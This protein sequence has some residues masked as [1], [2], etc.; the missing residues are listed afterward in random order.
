MEENKIVRKV[1]RKPIDSE[2]KSNVNNNAQSLFKIMNVVM[3]IMVFVIFIR[4]FNVKSTVREESKSTQEKVGEM[5]I[6]M[7]GSLE[8]SRQ[9]DKNEILSAFAL[10]SRLDV[11]ALKEREDYHKEQQT[12]YENMAKQY[13][14]GLTTLSKEIKIPKDTIK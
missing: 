7:I 6:D 14:Q 4:G 3:F 9:I 2:I 12:K 1:I 8:T 13:N 5:V 10:Y 11:T